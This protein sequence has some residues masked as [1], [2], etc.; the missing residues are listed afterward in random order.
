MNNLRKWQYEKLWKKDYETNSSKHIKLNEIIKKN[1][2][3]FTSLIQKYAKNH[4]WKNN[5]DKNEQNN[6][7]TKQNNFNN[8]VTLQKMNKKTFK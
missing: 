1:K 8:L 2:K 3:I 5:I 4:N 7:K 6:N